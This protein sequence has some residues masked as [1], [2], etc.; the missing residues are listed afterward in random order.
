M[1]NIEEDFKK[2]LAEQ[3]TK[4]KGIKEKYKLKYETN[5]L[6]ELLSFE[7]IEV[8]Y[9]EMKKFSGVEGNVCTMVK[10]I[11]DIKNLNETEKILLAFTLGNYSFMKYL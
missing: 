11:L 5:P 4:V 1:G 10:K 3:E 9:E 8:V 7:R 2:I 6:N